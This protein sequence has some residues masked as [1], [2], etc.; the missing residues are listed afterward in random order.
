MNRI[1]AAAYWLVPTLIT[2]LLYWPGLTAWF[3]KDDFAWLNLHSLADS[4]GLIHTLFHPYSQGTIRTI[5]ERMMFLSFYYLFGI[6]ALPFRCLGFLTHA[7][8]LLLLA[9]VCRKLTG[10][11]AAGFWAA[12]LYT[13]NSAIAVPLSW[14]CIYYELLCTFCFL[15]NLW[16][17]MRYAE[18]GNQRY[19]IWQW[20]A[21]LL[22]FGVLELNVV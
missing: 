11:R 4:N 19:F 13:A 16:L 8:N 22:G 3:Q 20:G 7:A 9:V 17:L 14:T 12:V 10:S 15:L 5:S 21:F 18:T 2:L 1:R 6:D